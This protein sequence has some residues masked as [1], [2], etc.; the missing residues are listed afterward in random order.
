MT[1]IVEMESLS[2]QKLRTSCD[3][4]ALLKVRCTK[5]RPSCERC[6]KATEPCVYTPYRWK[7]RPGRQATPLDRP[8]VA[9]TREPNAD[10]SGFT[11]DG[12]GI[13]ESFFIPD[14]LSAMGG[15]DIQAA[16]GAGDFM[17]IFGDGIPELS[18][19]TESSSS[20]M[21][22]TPHT[23]LT[24]DLPDQEGYSR[25]RFHIDNSPE[26]HYYHD[27]YHVVL[28]LLEELHNP[29]P[30]CKPTGAQLTEARPNRSAVRYSSTRIL[31]SNG[32]VIRHMNLL[33]AR[34][35]RVDCLGRP[36]STYLMQSIMSRLLSRYEDVFQ[37]I[38]DHSRREPPS[39][40]RQLDEREARGLARPEVIIFDPV[41]LDGFPLSREGEMRLNAELLV[42][43]LQGLAST[44]ASI[45]TMLVEVEC[46]IVEGDKE[47][48]THRSETNLTRATAVGPMKFVHDRLEALRALIREFR[49]TLV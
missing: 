37:C 1:A 9:G 47:Q 13:S 19:A 35:C 49:D 21:T 23:N 24:V 5:Q 28:G 27:C 36:E 30:Q 10:S 7:G 6:A 22:T 18:S 16:Q 43:E 39:T 8:P 42:C 17:N 41:Q 45:E 48:S 38:A 3:R 29:N 4:C 32:T 40:S 44:L 26:T 46:N 20:P 25:T 34:P 12:P 2:H 31:K 11:A 33:L 15:W 14:Q